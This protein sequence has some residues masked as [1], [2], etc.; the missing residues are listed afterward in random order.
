[1][2][3]LEEVF[4]QFKQ[5]P[6]WEKYP[7]PEV[8]YE[9]FKIQK[10]KPSNGIQECL[11]YQPPLSLPLNNGKVEIRKPAEGGVREIKEYQ[12][13][14]VEVTMIKDETDDDTKPD[15]DQ[16]SSTL[17]KECNNSETQPVSDRPSQDP[18]DAY[19]YISLSSAYRGAE[20]SRVLKNLQNGSS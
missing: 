4:E 18:S 10:P 2:T 1:M 9:H 8:F 5:L 12:V 17:P 13:L 14:P 6:D 16:N 19:P 7:M 20:Y 11:S 3:T 15:S